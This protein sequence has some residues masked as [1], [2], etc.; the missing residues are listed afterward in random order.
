MDGFEPEISEIEQSLVN[1][2]NEYSQ[3]RWY[4]QV[5]FPTGFATFFLDAGCL[6]KPEMETVREFNEFARTQS[7]IGFLQLVEKARETGSWLKQEHSRSDPANAG[8]RRG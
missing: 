5:K 8:S 2:L 7:G 4:Q 6:V 3:V 1:R